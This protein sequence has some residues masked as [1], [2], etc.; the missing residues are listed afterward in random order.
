MTKKRS[1]LPQP[2]APPPQSSALRSRKRARQVTT[3]FHKYTRERDAALAR[4]ATLGCVRPEDANDPSLVELREE[5]KMWDDKLSEIGGREEY[6]RASQMNTLLF[7]TSKWLLGV[8]GRWGWLDGLPVS[9]DIERGSADEVK[10]NVTHV[11][12]E[13]K[14]GRGK[15]RRRDVRLLEVGA[16]NTQ[17]IEAAARTRTRTRTRRY[18]ENGHE[19]TQHMN[20]IERVHLL[21]VRAIDIRSTDPRIQQMDFFDLPT[22]EPNSLYDVVVNSMVINCVTTPD[23]R[24]RMLSLCFRHLRP[25]GVCF[26]T[27]PKLCLIQSKFMSRSYFEEI[28][29]RGVGFEILHEVG[30][31]SP[32][33]AFFVLRRPKEERSDNNASVL[34]NWDER[35][36]R[37]PVLHRGKKFRNDF[38][39]TLNEGTVDGR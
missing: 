23:A 22:P 15:S 28:L 21:D 7:S 35:F 1:R 17:L 30:R 20:E 36:M 18:Y 24:G 34:R 12:G 19:H 4:A 13:K 11:H 29:T 37:M 38:A 26:L 39:V 32:K 2:L 5:V 25:G 3:L 31:E 14:D 8:L 6:Q 10:S 33:I 27:L 9:F 16:I